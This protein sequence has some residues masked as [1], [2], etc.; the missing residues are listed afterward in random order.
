[1]L[2]RN[3]IEPS[4]SPYNSPIILVPKKSQD[5]SRKWRFCIDYRQLNKHIIPD[6]FPL[7]RI[8]DILDSLG[9]AKFFSILD[10]FSGFHQVALHPDS[11]DITSFSTGRGSFRFKTLP[12]GL[13][14]APNSFARMMSLAFSGLNPS[15]SFLYLDDLIVVGASEKHH[16]KNLGSVFE[17]I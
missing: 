3:I 13:N 9:R 11:R 5:G 15:T 7:P 12:F 6:R 14:I 16:L 17:T 8:D 4:T 2:S 1:M 10:L